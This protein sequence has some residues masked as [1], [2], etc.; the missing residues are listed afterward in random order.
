MMRR[1]G[2]AQRL[3]VHSRDHYLQ[4]ANCIR[5]MARPDRI[6]AFQLAILGDPSFKYLF[7]TSRPLV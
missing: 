5:D 6:F 2:E 3:G 4:I 1:V 7:E